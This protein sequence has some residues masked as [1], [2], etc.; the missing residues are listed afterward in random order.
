MKNTDANVERF[1]GGNS[2]PAYQPA[3]KD[4]RLHQPNAYFS[5]QKFG[6]LLTQLAP[7]VPEVVMHSK[8][9]QAVFLF[10][11]NFFSSVMYGQISPKETIRQMRTMLKE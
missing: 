5:N 7:E 9:P 3:W 2:F 10:Q 8:R 1:V 11:E 4:E 6:D